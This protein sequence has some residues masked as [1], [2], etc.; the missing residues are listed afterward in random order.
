MD[1]W[2]YSAKVL[3]KN[4]GSLR[5]GS[6]SGCARLL[7]WNPIA[8]LVH[9]AAIEGEVEGASI[10][11][12]HEDLCRDGETMERPVVDFD[13]HL[14]SL[15]G[16]DSGRLDVGVE[17]ADKQALF[18][19]FIGRHEVNDRA[20]ADD[21]KVLQDQTVVKQFRERCA[22]HLAVNCVALFSMGDLQ[23]LHGF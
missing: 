15:V 12:G 23:S 9:G 10:G 19:G 13:V 22:A 21:V 20:P 1:I 8:L 16:L 14:L 4:V 17:A 6:G 2:I 5:R 11:N 18:C 3:K 7:F